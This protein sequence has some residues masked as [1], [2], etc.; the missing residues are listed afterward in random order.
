MFQLIIHNNFNVSSIE[1]NNQKRIINF[2]NDVD[3]MKKEKEIVNVDFVKS[4][5]LN[6]NNL[7]NKSMANTQ[8][9]EKPV[10]KII[11]KIIE[12]P[13]EKIIEKIVEKPIYIEKP[14]EKIVEKPIVKIVEKFVE[15]PIEKIVEKPVEKIIEKHIIIE[16]PVEKIV[17]KIVEKPVEKIVEKIVEKPVEKIVEKIVEKP[18]EKIVEKII[19]KPVEKIIE[20]IVEKPIEKIIEKIIE[21]PSE[22]RA[23]KTKF[24]IGDLSIESPITNLTIESYLIKNKYINS[25]YNNENNNIKNIEKEKEE[26][27]EDEIDDNNFN[28]D[29]YMMKKSEEINIDNDINNS[30]DKGNDNDNNDINNIQKDK[31][32]EN[33]MEKSLI[34]MNSFEVYSD[35]N[36]KDIMSEKSKGGNIFDDI[37]TIKQLN[38]EEKSSITTKKNEIEKKKNI[39]KYKNTCISKI[40]ELKKNKNI[41]IYSSPYSQIIKEIKKTF[42]QN[43][44]NMLEI[45]SPKNDGESIYIFNPYL[46]EIEEIL[47]PSK[48]KFSK[49]FAYLNL[50]PYCFVS[51]GLNDNIILNSFYCIRRTGPRSFDFINLSPMLIERYNHSMIELKFMGDIAVVGGFN[52]RKCEMYTLQKEWKGLP[53]L[54]HVRE[55]PSCCVINEKNIF[56]FLGYDNELNKYNDTIEKLNLNA[57]S[58]RWE[59]IRPIGMKQIMERKA[60]SCLVYNHKGNDYIFIVGGIN[61][62]E[63]ET[64]DILIFDE[65][66]NK[67]NRKKKRLPF[68]CSFSQNSFNLLCSGYY[69]NFDMN[70]EVIQYERLGEVFFTLSSK[71]N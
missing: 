10:E 68:K 14:V 55:S 18:V 30:N 35:E 64:N 61:N 20:K 3:F 33:L 17:E 6:E 48:Y 57:K 7:F 5:T 53:D 58:I 66:E 39:E 9:I 2:K 36:I 4:Q 11:E 19:E 32:M 27:K 63:K 70:S 8:I 65:K 59:E 24:S 37:R 44:N 50:L 41:N 47:I 29:E 38:R 49:N 23:N 45:L 52:S 69:C 42:N 21:K 54:N 56:C 28:I 25:E 16:K 51:G 12:K 71:K 26:K 22:T 60:S 43:D 67:I 34:F 15:K 1:Y 62:I 13:V 46:N 40:K 31:K